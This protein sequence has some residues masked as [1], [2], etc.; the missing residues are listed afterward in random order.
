MPLLSRI[1]AHANWFLA[2]SVF[3][4]LFV[5]DLATFARPAL[6]PAVGL[7]LVVALLRVDEVE[8]V[9]TV[10]RRGSDLLMVWLTLMVLTPFCVLALLTAI[11][12][13][14]WMPA[15]LPTAMLMA[16]STA[17]L[18][19][20]VSMSAI[21]RLDSALALATVLAA[22]VTVPAVTPWMTALLTGL[23]L[24]FDIWAFAERLALLI[25]GSIA[26]ALTVRR[27]VSP[28]RLT[29]ARTQMDGVFVLA[30][31]TVALG[32]M[33]GLGGYVLEQPG[34]ATLF[35]A[36]SFVL[37]LVLQAIAA[38]CYWAL[39][40][41]AVVCRHGPS[42]PAIG[43]RRRELLTVGL[44]GGF[45][46]LAFLIATLPA[47]ADREIILFFALA[48]FPIYLMPLL[49]QAVY[50]RLLATADRPHV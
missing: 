19:G 38:G 27:I 39:S 11:Q 12:A 20:T 28:A 9:A 21:A 25:L 16:A 29:V 15:A 17:S 1:G 5:P 31:G 14:R 34:R 24:A 3:V 10:T 30:M 32:M 46:N 43:P 8:I 26:V 22:T 41:I 37:N 45:R 40:V 36:A 18:I 35:V 44:L 13:E 6:A 42:S 48:Q 47:S 2:A 33:D 49:T 7:L 23:S 4:G 50:R